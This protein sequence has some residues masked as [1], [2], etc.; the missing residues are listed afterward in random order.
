MNRSAPVGAGL[1]CSCV[2]HEKRLARAQ[3]SPSWTTGCL[4][5]ALY[6]IFEVGFSLNLELSDG[7]RLAGQQASRICLSLPLQL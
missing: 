4:L 2:L 1:G 6:L 7:A 3:Q 5:I